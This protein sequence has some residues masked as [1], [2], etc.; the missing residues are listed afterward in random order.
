MGIDYDA[1]A[2]FGWEIDEENENKFRQ[3]LKEVFNIKGSEEF[4]FWQGEEVDNMDDIIQ[5]QLGLPFSLTLTGNFYCD[6]ADAYILLVGK[7]I[8]G[9]KM[10][11]LNEWINAN[12][13]TLK[14]IEEI[15]GTPPY[16]AVQYNVW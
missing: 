7:R 2:A 15:M 5:K 11:E 3:V 16:F 10:D 1:R 8:E 9:K 14:K 12:K 6:T 4:S 13:E